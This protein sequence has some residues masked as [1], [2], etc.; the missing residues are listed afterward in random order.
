MLIDAHDPDS[1]SVGSFFTNPVLPAAEIPPDAPQW[2]AGDG[3]VKTSAAWLIEQ[4]GFGRGYGVGPSR[5]VDQAHP[6]VGQPRG[7]I[8]VR[9][10]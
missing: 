4:A 10:H 5:P 7:R 2:P 8:D 6:R 3:L 9:A 1:V